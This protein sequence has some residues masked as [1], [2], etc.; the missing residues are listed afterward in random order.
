MRSDTNS[1]THSSASSSTTSGTTPAAVAPEGGRPLTA[2][3]AIL[4]SVVAAVSLTTG[5]IMAVAGALGH[6]FSPWKSA[7]PVSPGLIG[8]AMA[9]VAPGLFAISRARVWEEVRTLVLPLLIVLAGTFTVTLLNAGQLQAAAGGSAVLVLF[10]LGWVAILGALALSALLAVGFQYAKPAAP[11]TTPGVPL[12]NWSKPLVAVLGSSW[13]GIGTGLL[14]RPDFWDAFV[15]WTVN[16]PDA[17][18]LGIWAVALG[19]GVLGSLAEDDLTRLRPA[20][21]AL[22]GVALALTVVLAARAGSVAWTSGPGLSL[23]ALV[24]GLGASGLTGSVLAR[25]TRQ[26]QR[27]PS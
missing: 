27:R 14:L 12:P 7:L 13:L 6:T 4:A 23:V 21:R 3:I 2:G 20:L 11:I 9:G 5:G 22:P 18:G 24:L 16:R 26:R 25:R 8:A 19:T 10:S 1:E 17:Q 15:P